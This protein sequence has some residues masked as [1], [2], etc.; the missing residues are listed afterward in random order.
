LFYFRTLEHSFIFQNTGISKYTCVK[1]SKLTT[2][3]YVCFLLFKISTS[4]V[5][6]KNLSHYYCRRRTHTVSILLPQEPR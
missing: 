2:Y 3:A 5:V 6:Y 4:N 1:T